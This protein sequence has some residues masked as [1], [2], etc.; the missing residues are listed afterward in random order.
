MPATTKCIIIDIDDSFDLYGAFKAKRQIGGI[1]AI[2]CF[3]KGNLSYVPDFSVAGSDL[4]QV[5]IFFKQV[6]A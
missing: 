2:L 1:P 5:N 4:E 6:L 3:N